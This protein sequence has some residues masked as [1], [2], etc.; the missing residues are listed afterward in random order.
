MSGSL[1]AQGAPAVGAERVIGAGRDPKALG[2]LY[3]A[4]A[5]TV[6]P[7]QDGPDALEQALAEAVSATS[8]GLVLD[9]LWGPVTE[10]FFAALGRSGEGAGANTA[11]V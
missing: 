9:C 5:T 11:H 1:A 7:A 2:R 6:L 4:G 8:P 10:A 3:G